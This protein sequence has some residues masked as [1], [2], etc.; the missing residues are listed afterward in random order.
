MRLSGQ[1][2]W[3]RVDDAGA[4]IWQGRTE[5]AFEERVSRCKEVRECFPWVEIVEE[6]SWQ[7]WRDR[8]WFRGPG[9]LMSLW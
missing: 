3:S 1:R 9:G 2:V 6:K 7:R 5:L 4:G 8:L